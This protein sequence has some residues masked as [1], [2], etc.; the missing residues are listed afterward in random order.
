MGDT[1]DMTTLKRAFQKIDHNHDGIISLEELQVRPCR[2]TESNC[3]ERF[4]NADSTGNVQASFE[5]LES[6]EVSELWCALDQATA[7]S[8]T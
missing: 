6:A 1:G 3:D 5:D 2:S 4:L 8:T 7:G